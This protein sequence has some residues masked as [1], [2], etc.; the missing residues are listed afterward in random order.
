[1]PNSHY[2]LFQTKF[3]VTRKP[4]SEIPQAAGDQFHYFY[5]KFSLF[6]ISDTKFHVTRKPESEIRK[7][8]AEAQA[9][10]DQFASF[11]AQVGLVFVESLDLLPS[12]SGSV[13]T[14]HYTTVEELVQKTYGAK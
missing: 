14:F 7:E 2:F 5:S 9:A 3:E 1:M 13:D 6:P 10:G 11:V 4:E 12:R 8:F